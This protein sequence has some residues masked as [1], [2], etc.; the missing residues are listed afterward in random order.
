M[1]KKSL[2]EYLKKLDNKDKAKRLRNV[3]EIFER[4]VSEL[5]KTKFETHPSAN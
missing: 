4:V 1:D 2:E 5:K 3:F